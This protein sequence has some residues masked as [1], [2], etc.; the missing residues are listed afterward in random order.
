MGRRVQPRE[1]YARDVQTLQRLVLVVEADTVRPVA[2]RRKVINKLLEVIT[3]FNDD[4][5]ER[6]SPNRAGAKQPKSQSSQ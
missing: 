2:W 5:S 1:S 3:I 6:L 4:T